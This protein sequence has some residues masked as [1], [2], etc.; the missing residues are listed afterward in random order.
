MSKDSEVLIRAEHVSKK[1]CRSL[2]RSLWYGVQDMATA[3]NP[4]HQG[5]GR[6]GSTR[7]LRND[8]FWAVRDV[9]FEVKRGEC[10]GLIGHNGAGKST[11]LKML[12]S[13]NRPDE[14]RITMRGRVGALIELG[15]GFKPIL[16]GREN[17]YN[18]AALLGF[19]K[20]ETDAKLDAIID[21][22][23]LEDF[24]DMPMQNYSS[25]MKVKLGF[26][27]SSQMEPDV[28][29]ID[30]VLAVGDLGFRFKCLNKIADLLNNCAVV[31]VSHSMPQVMRVATDIMVLEGGRIGYHGSDV[32]KGLHTYFNLFDE[33]GLKV[34]GSGEV[35]VTSVRAASG[36]ESCYSTGAINAE[37]GCR[38]RFEIEMRAEP[39]IKDAVIQVLLWN[40]EM[41]PVLDIVDRGCH[42]FKFSPGDGRTEVAVEID[43][44]PL[45]AGRYQA[46]IIVTHP[47][48]ERVYCQ[49]DHAVSVTV[50]TGSPASGAGCVSLGHWRHVHSNL[51]LAT[52]ETLT[53]READGQKI[54][55]DDLCIFDEICPG[56]VAIDCGANVG[57]VTELMAQRGA[58]VHSFEPDPAAFE[59]LRQ[60]FAGCENVHLH[61]QAVSNRSGTMRLY[62]REEHAIDPVKFS[63]GSTLHS[64]KSDVNLATY[65]DVEVVSL[66]DFLQQFDRI[67]ILKL[68]IEGAECDVLDDLIEKG[69]FGKIDLTLVETHEEWIP[70]TIPRL[71]TI[72]RKLVNRDINNVYLNWI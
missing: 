61:N 51:S 27:V 21:F 4:W 57:I 17:I 37:H 16:T 38:L 69:G 23:E 49:M 15:A 3:L 54:S 31:F 55:Q 68:D 70:E 63:V 53:R 6:D 14:G 29:L 46:S 28:L 36:T 1:F 32:S 48:L 47:G 11:L 43:N 60:K 56:D 40:H 66:S 58:Q 59:V 24:L 10:L 30:E 35:T 12:N 67:R 7:E 19:S 34:T 25:G 62:Y 33:G 8:E 65:A 41:L 9:S 52:R 18:Q 2:R 50:S 26:A 39:H 44:L 20:R 45:N 72:K 22:S 64:G 5:P 71:E 13:L 42:G